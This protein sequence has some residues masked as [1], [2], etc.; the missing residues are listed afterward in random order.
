MALSHIKVVLTA[1]HEEQLSHFVTVQMFFWS[2]QRFSSGHL[3][4]FYDSDCKSS[5]PAM[6]TDPEDVKKISWKAL[7]AP[8]TENKAHAFDTGWGTDLVSL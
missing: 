3:G 4:A 6:E 8:F 5:P 7:I 2:S 1:G